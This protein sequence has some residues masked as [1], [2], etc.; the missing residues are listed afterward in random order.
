LKT[1]LFSDI[2]QES[3]HQIDETMNNSFIDKMWL[4]THSTAKK[5][6]AVQ[7]FSQTFQT[8][9]LSHYETY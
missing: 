4:V 1:E 3:F 9:F 6:M 2:P 8:F 5:S 7:F